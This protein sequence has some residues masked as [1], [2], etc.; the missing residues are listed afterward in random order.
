MHHIGG[1]SFEI[2]AGR[3]VFRVF[4]QHLVELHTGL[5][6]FAVIIEKKTLFE[7]R[8]DLFL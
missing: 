8:F 5:C 3:L 1:G 4:F 2:Y 6:K 7:I